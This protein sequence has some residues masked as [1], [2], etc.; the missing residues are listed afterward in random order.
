MDMNVRFL[1]KNGHAVDISFE[2]MTNSLRIDT[3]IRRRV[4]S[5][6]SLSAVDI[7]LIVSYE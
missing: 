7:S 2:K 6:D 1:A 3:L 4:A 5:S